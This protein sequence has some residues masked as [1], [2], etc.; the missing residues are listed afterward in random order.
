MFD[1]FNHKSRRPKKPSEYKTT[2]HSKRLHEATEDHLNVIFDKT[3][4]QFSVAQKVRLA[5]AVRSATNV[6][7][8]AYN[9]AQNDFEDDLQRVSFWFGAPH[10][11]V[12]RIVRHSVE[13]LYKVMVD[14][15]QFITFYGKPEPKVV[16]DLDEYYCHVSYTL[17]GEENKEDMYVPENSFD[18]SEERLIAKYGSR[19]EEQRLQAH[20]RGCN[21]VLK[22]RRMFTL[23]DFISPSA[24]SNNLKLAF[25]V[26]TVKSRFCRPP[27]THLFEH[28][29][30]GSAI[31][32][33]PDALAFHVRETDFRQII[34]HQLAYILLGANDPNARVG[35]GTK[36]L[37]QDNCQRNA[38]SNPEVTLTD[39][40]NLGCFINSFAEPII[41]K[42]QDRVN[43]MWPKWSETEDKDHVISGKV[44]R[45]SIVISPDF[46]S[47][48][49]KK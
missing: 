41:K 42:E 31:Y 9:S 15:S 8:I 4:M 26:G 5:N 6:L 33:E 11:D 16:Q 48:A 3:S 34:Y 35:I 37:L 1:V 13:T 23:D 47:V 40:G 25:D 28:A 36:P 21:H 44:H 17:P 49:Y 45:S 32:I 24:A 46:K 22:R 39:G 27:A 10:P 12:L 19:Y 29:A 38:V 43:R 7:R 20:V 30:G 14:R 2:F 18:K